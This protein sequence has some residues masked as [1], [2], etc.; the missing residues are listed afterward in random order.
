MPTENEKREI[1][2]R[3]AF[4]I[5]GVFE[6]PS[7]STVQTVDSGIISY[8]Q[9]Q[10]TLASGTLA[11][12]V[13]R[14]CDSA[15][16]DTA[17]Q[18]KTFL[19]KVTAK[20]AALKNNE[21]FLN[22][23]RAAGKEQK[24]IDA[25]DSVFIEKYWNPAIERAVSEGVKSPLGFALFYDTN[26]QGGLNATIGR[27]KTKLGTSAVSEQK[28]LKTFLECRRDRLLELAAEQIL[29]PNASTRKN[30][31]MLKS[32]AKNRIGSLI[33]L[34]DANNLDL[35][36]TFDINGTMVKG[37][38]AGG[39]G[40]GVPSPLKEGDKSEAV[41]VLQD[42]FVRLG[43]LTTEQIGTNRGT[44]GPKTLKAVKKF[45]TDLGLA[46]TG[47]FADGEQK[48]LETIFT[49]I[50][51]TKPNPAITRKIQDALVARGYLK[52]S[53]IGSAHGTFGPKTDD[54]VKRFQADK[55]LGQDGEVGPN[56]FKALFNPSAAGE[57]SSS[58]GG[59]SATAGGKPTVTRA[60]FELHDPE[61]NHY[62]VDV[63]GIG[64]IRITEG[65]LVLGPHSKKT[66]VKAIL[67]NGKLHNVPNGAK[68]NLGIDYVIDGADKRVKE[69]FGGRVA[70]AI[71]SSTGY[72]NRV[73]VKTNLTYKH[74]GANHP[75]FTHYAH[76]D[77]ILV[78]KGQNIKAGDFIGVMGNT[79]GSHGA[80]VDQRFWIEV[81]GGKIELSPN[82]LV[83]VDS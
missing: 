10:A 36:G 61:S 53:D 43:Y 21:T 46:E 70:D 38:D 2:R 32:A 33:K 7:Y 14:Y 54:A 65:F 24:M 77:S 39:D 28:Y 76:L 3:V 63:S 69:W 41:G 42:N 6:A 48:A 44:F 27:V 25:Q 58:T 40:A 34:V 80:H 11:V 26:V 64:T 19:P 29:S 83:V 71:H 5:T 82:L 16:S 60:F 13:K 50:S 81:G 47:I 74:N 23:L 59:G 66:G 4:R 79:G 22:L 62:N 73:I 12:I 67:G 49:G 75:V 72:G 35:T 52:T 37:S 56:T 51:K 78:S 17:K 18:L 30:G 55:N 8:G 1:A 68:V 9:H 57:G 15:D 45:Q 20:D 31:E